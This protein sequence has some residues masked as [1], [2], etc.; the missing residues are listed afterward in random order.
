MDE[1][2]AL[3]LTALHAASTS[4]SLEVVRLLLEAGAELNV[5]ASDEETPLGAAARM[6]HLEIVRLLHSKVLQKKRE[7]ERYK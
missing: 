6:G 2:T 5:R 4:G 7:R 3:G 1:R